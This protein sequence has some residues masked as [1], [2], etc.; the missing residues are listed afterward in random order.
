MKLGST[1]EEAAMAIF[2]STAI[3]SGQWQEARFSLG[4]AP[5]HFTHKKKAWDDMVSQL[6]SILKTCVARAPSVSPTNLEPILRDVRLSTAPE[7]V[8][9]RPEDDED[10]LKAVLSQMQVVL[11][12]GANIAGA[13]FLRRR[14]T[15]V[16]EQAK[17]TLATVDLD[18]APAR[19]VRAYRYDDE[20]KRSRDSQMRFDGIMFVATLLATRLG[21]HIATEDVRSD[22]RVTVL[23]NGWWENSFSVIAAIQRVLQARVPNTAQRLS[24]ERAFRDPVPANELLGRFRE[25]ADLPRNGPTPPPERNITILGQQQ[26]EHEVAQD[27][28]R[29]STGNLGQQLKEKAALNSFEPNLGHSGRQKVLLPDVG[30]KSRGG[31]GGGAG[32]NENKKDRELAGLI[33]EV[34]VYEQLRVRLSGFDEMAW[35]SCNRNAYGL[36]GGGDDALG[37]DFLYRDVENQ[38]AGRAD[39]PL[40]HIEVKSSSGDG[41]EA[42]PMSTNE[43]ERARE[44]HQT[45]NTVYIILRVAHVRNDPMISDVIIDPFALY[46]EGQV[47]IV[48]RD[49]WVHVG[50]PQSTAATAVEPQTVTW[51]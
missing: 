8:A 4:M 36:Q 26:T 6:V 50:R 23:L 37:Y 35:C 46:G 5:W 17:A 43:W 27:L 21:E 29:G 42:F 22:S 9:C 13:D 49:I 14:L 47:G 25:M 24:D 1:E 31:G 10:T 18:D 33:G 20:S 39:Q 30:K 38:L 15:V 19:D 45:A 34:F 41:S 16:V 48:S 44:C 2:R 12:E 51:T 11:D 40:C 3:S 32:T 7:R 28:L